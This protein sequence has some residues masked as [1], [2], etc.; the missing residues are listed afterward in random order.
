MSFQIFWALDLYVPI[1][2]MIGE[3]FTLL[4]QSKLSACSTKCIVSYHICVLPYAWCSTACMLSYHMRGVILYAWCLPH[5]R[6]ST[7]CTVVYRTHGALLHAWCSTACMVFCYMHG[8]LLHAWF[9]ATCMVLYCRHGVLLHAWCSIA[10]MVFCHMHGVLPHAW[11]SATCTVFYHMHGV[12]PHARYSTTGMVFFHMHG[13]ILH[14]WYLPRYM[15]VLLHTQ[16]YTVC[17]VFYHMHGVLLHARCSIV[18]TVSINNEKTYG[19]SFLPCPPSYVHWILRHP[20]QNRTFWVTVIKDTW[21]SLRTHQKASSS[22]L[23]VISP[24]NSYIPTHWLPAVAS[25][26]VY[27]YSCEICMW[28]CVC[29]YLL[30]G[31]W[32]YKKKAIKHSTVCSTQQGAFPFPL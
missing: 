11:C 20:S 1:L 27:M 9:Y 22:N 31:L 4:N 24:Q 5:A 32:V 17:M 15:G 14:A 29:V 12:V 6:C 10:C 21:L 3:K 18:C 13:V 8:I 26:Y 28:I 7:I 30:I 23:F 16:C 19:V 2:N 25:S